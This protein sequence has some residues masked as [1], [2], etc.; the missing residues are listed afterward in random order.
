MLGRL[1]ALIGASVG[2][3]FVDASTKSRRQKVDPLIRAPSSIHRHIHRAL[4]IKSMRPKDVDLD[5]D[6][7]TFRK[8]I[9]ANAK[10]E[11][12][13]ESLN[14]F[15]VDLEAGK[16]FTEEQ[17]EKLKS[18]IDAIPGFENKLARFALVMDDAL[19]RYFDMLLPEAVNRCPVTSLLSQDGRKDR[20]FYGGIVNQNS[21]TMSL[22]LVAAKNMKEAMAN[23]NLEFADDEGMR[24]NFMQVFRNF[25]S[26]LFGLSKTEMNAVRKL[27]NIL[28]FRG[29]IP[30]KNLQYHFNEKY[31]AFDDP[32]K[33]KE[34]LPKKSLIRDLK[35]YRKY[36]PFYFE[37]QRMRLN[38]FFKRAALGC[39]ALTIKAPNG[40][41][42]IKVVHDFISDSFEKTV[43]PSLDRAFKL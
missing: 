33:P 9:D 16:V 29:K 30:P 25:K 6:F 11:A 40:D 38:L 14:A 37:G 2:A 13:Q 22:A 19:A 1:V 4:G 43:L 17:V 5:R 15:C 32:S 36:F 21:T 42:F 23:G 41:N 27:Y 8:L 35:R 10:L 26:L 31:F 7:E 18:E 20:N 34:L 28:G 24:Q 12:M 39:P 3:K